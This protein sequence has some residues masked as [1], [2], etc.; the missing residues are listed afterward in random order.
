MK[1]SR[2]GEFGIIQRVKNVFESHSSDVKISIGDDAAVFK[3]HADLWMVITTDALV[4]GVHFDLSYTPLKSLGWKLMAV[5]I[6]DIAAM[7]AIPRTGVISLA[8]PAAWT[9]KKIDLLSQGIAACCS[10]YNCEVIGGDTVRS[11]NSAFLSAAVTGEVEPKYCA[12]RSAAE[13]GDL[14]C[15]TGVLGRALAGFRILSSSLQKKR[16]E[17]AV[18]HFLYPEPRVQEARIL[19]KEVGINALI[20]ISDGLAAEIHHLCTSSNKGCLIYGDKIPIAGELETGLS[21]NDETPLF[22][23]LQSGEEYELL[24][25]ITEGNFKILEKKDIFKNGLIS[26]IGTVRDKREGVHLLYNNKKILLPNQGWDHFK[27]G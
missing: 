20:D 2:L 26:V 25:T 27:S 24:F 15:V 1:L 4:E 12:T 17:K 19:V 13:S 5:N 16:R 14:I 23:V 10:R 6:S 11:Q 7:G 3:S 22:S 8:I 21:E 9:S 18:D